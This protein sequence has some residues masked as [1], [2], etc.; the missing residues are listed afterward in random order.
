MNAVKL[1]KIECTHSYNKGTKP[2]SL[3]STLISH[4]NADKTV[5]KII[6]CIGTII[7]CLQR[8]DQDENRVQPKSWARFF[9]VCQKAFL[10]CFPLGN[11][12]SSSVLKA[13]KS[14]W[15]H[16]CK[17]QGALLSFQRTQ[18]TFDRNSHDIII[19]TNFLSEHKVPYL[20]EI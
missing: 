17:R 1:N 10:D 19:Y 13:Y 11:L 20:A 5:F 4:E 18:D 7:K 12:I 16:E 14:S 15:K 8:D 6:E 3:S 9:K 2:C